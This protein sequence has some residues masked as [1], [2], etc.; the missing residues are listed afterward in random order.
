MA[1]ITATETVPVVTKKDKLISVGRAWKNTSKAGNEFLRLSIDQKID[2]KAFSAITLKAGDQ[3]LLTL[4]KK[5]EGKKD[6][7]FRLSIVEKVA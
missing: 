3:L 2:G 1:V 4:N 6:A 5:R 7:D